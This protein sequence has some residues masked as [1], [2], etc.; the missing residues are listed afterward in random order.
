MYTEPDKDEVFN[1]ISWSC[2]QSGPIIAAAGVKAVIRVIQ[3]NAATLT[4]Y[5]NLVGH[6]G[7]INDLKFHPTQSHILLTCSKD[8]SIRLWNVKNS[9]CVAIF[10][11]IRGHRDEVLAVDI[12][13]D[14]KKF[15]SGGIDHNVMV[16]SLNC[17]E[18]NEKIAK[19]E[20]LEAFGRGSAFAA[21]RLHFP[22]FST[23]DV[24]GNYVDSVK[25][26][27]DSFLTKSCENNIIWWKVKEAGNGNGL[28][29]SK[30][31]TFDIIESDIWYMKMDLDLSM[32]YLAVG[33]QT[34]KVFV[35][36]LNT[37]VPVNRR[38]A[39]IHLKCNS[40]VRQITF[41]RDSQILIAACDDG[42]I[43]RWD[44]KKHF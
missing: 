24:H 44:K 39:L 11:G 18:I 42:S 35:F 25:F 31:F 43:W 32:N 36:D 38:S 22:E 5:K 15:I 29:V 6:T 3:C 41:S 2:D 27:G 4:S 21:I 37:D 26:F 8:Y 10:A 20:E 16:W 17:E 14:G 1:A 12:S 19:S 23:R 40:A 34:G 33:S 13:S 30:L 28:V 9:T 7:A